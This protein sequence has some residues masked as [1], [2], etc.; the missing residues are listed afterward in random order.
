MYIEWTLRQV[1]EAEN[2]MSKASAISQAY[3]LRPRYPAGHFGQITGAVGFAI[4]PKWTDNETSCPK[5][6][7]VK[8]AG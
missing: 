3:T 2:C 4:R 6:Y 5:H 8:I 1:T 7:L